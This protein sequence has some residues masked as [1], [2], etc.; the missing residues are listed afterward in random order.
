METRIVFIDITNSLAKS[1]YFLKIQ[2]IGQ[3]IIT[4][5]RYFIMINTD[6]KELKKTLPQQLQEI[7]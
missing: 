1:S 3:E 5:L 4:S 6:K 7:C 2:N